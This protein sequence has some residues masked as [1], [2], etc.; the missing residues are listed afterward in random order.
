MGFLVNLAARILHL[1]PRVVRFLISGGTAQVVE[2]AFLYLLTDIV[3]WWYEFSFCVAF[4]ITF[5]VSFTMQKFWTF[6]DAE[7]S[8]IHEQASVYFIVAVVNFV[9]NTI[10]LYILVEYAHLWYLLAQLIISGLIAIG[11]FLIYKFY[12]FNQDRGGTAHA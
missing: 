4:L 12:I 6:E 2:L 3:G 10:A 9:I 1:S 7:T 11:S 5:C 8:D